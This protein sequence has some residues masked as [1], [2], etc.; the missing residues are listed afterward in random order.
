[1]SLLEF[2]LQCLIGHALVSVE[3]GLNTQ[4]TERLNKDRL[5]DKVENQE[6]FKTGGF[7]MLWY[8]HARPRTI[9]A[10]P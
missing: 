8:T 7:S 3:Q 9:P 5:K 4:K 10:Q 6:D 1:M 2:P